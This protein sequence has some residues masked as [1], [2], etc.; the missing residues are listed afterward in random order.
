[1]TAESTSQPH[2]FDPDAAD[3]HTPAAT[4]RLLGEKGAVLSKQLWR[5]A[6]RLKSVRDL[7]RKH[8]AGL[9]IETPFGRQHMT[10][11]LLATL[12]ARENALLL[13][14]PGV[15]KGEIAQRVFSLLG[16]EQPRV[17]DTPPPLP[18]DS[19]NMA[20]WW[21]ERSH[22][23][24]SKNKYFRYLLSRFTQPEELFGPIEIG[25]LKRGALVRVNFGLLTGPGVRAAFLDEVFK[26]SSAILNGLLTI[27]MERQYFNWGGMVDS[28]LLMFIGASNELP[29]G[30]ASGHLGVGA[31]GEDFNA[32]HAFL[33]RF[34]MRFDVPVASASSNADDTAGGIQSSNLALATGLALDREAARFTVSDPFETGDKKET[35]PA[36]INDVVLAGRALLQREGVGGPGGSVFDPNSLNKFRN[37]FFLLAADLQPNATRS[38]RGRVAWT[39]T[40]RKL[41][42]LYKICLAHA[43]VASKEFPSKEGQ[44]LLGLD[45][46]NL[47]AF[48][49]I[50]DSPPARDELVRHVQKRAKRGPT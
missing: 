47:W 25:L 45:I 41:K 26:A 27:L 50:W 9:N 7:L 5:S 32:L 39:I 48:T 34:P 15:A 6:A 16:L 29:G 28:D 46:A 24:R 30:F 20:A 33:D 31:S 3:F 23:E 42:A 1:M 19:T 18:G 35:S 40:P 12:I 22:Q 17:G 2:P 11:W 37:E 44:P 49:F 14:M 36:S 21:R 10:D 4:Q 8:W 38:Q 43:L 13:G